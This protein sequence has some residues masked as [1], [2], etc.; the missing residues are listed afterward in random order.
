MK[1]P[2]A[3]HPTSRGSVLKDLPEPTTDDLE[4]RVCGDQ[5]DDDVPI[6]LVELYI[7]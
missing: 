7:Q 5:A 1:V 6:E 2:A 4:V 3:T